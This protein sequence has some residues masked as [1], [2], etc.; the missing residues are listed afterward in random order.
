VHHE[1]Q[2]D[3]Y[4]IST[5][6]GRLDLAAIH[7]FLTTAYWSPG[8]PLE[9]VRRAIEDSVCFGIL[10]GDEQAGFGRVV[11]DRATFGYLCD[12]FVLES[13]RG[14]GLS[15]WL[16][17]CIDAHPDL[18]GFRRWM[19]FTRDAHGLYRQYGYTPLANSDRCMERWTPDVYKRGEA[20]R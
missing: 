1:W 16:M 15:K 10:R 20:K 11:T 14:R 17:E 4:T 3:G 18:Q 7:G 19:L 2:R 5:D 13:H 9:T 6:P 12:V 8:I